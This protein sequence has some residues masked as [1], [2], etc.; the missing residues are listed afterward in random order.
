[1]GQNPQKQDSVI[2]GTHKSKRC[3]LDIFNK[4][5]MEDGF[6]VLHLRLS[7]KSFRPKDSEG[8]IVGKG[9]VRVPFP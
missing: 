2:D 7:K 1:M 3:L 4:K 9:T 8:R 5:K 6:S